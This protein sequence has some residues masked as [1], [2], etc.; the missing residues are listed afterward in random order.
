M[1]EEGYIYITLPMFY[2]LRQVYMVSIN[3][4]AYPDTTKFKENILKARKK[5]KHID[6]VD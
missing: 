5:K 1:Y 4:L 3:D 6:F 2:I